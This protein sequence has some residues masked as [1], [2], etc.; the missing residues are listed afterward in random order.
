MQGLTQHGIAVFAKV[1]RL[2]QPAQIFDRH[3]PGQVG[4]IPVPVKQVKGGRRFAQ[5]V[6]ANRRA[7]D[8]VVRA[9]VAEG[10]GHEIGLQIALLARL[11]LD[12]V[13]EIVLQEHAGFALVREIGQCSEERRRFDRP[14]LALVQQCQRQAQRRAGD[15]VAYRVDRLDA[16]DLLDLG[17]GGQKAL[18]DIGIHAD[19]GILRPRIDPA[20][21]EQ[22]VALL[23]D[24]LYQTVLRLQIQNV[25]LVDPGRKD[26]QR[27]FVHLLG[28]G[29]VLNQLEHAV[30]EHHL[31]L[32]RADIAA[33]LERLA[34][35]QRDQ[36]LAFVALQ[37]GDQVF[38][39]LDQALALGLDR[40]HQRVR[41]GAQ[42]IRRRHHV[43][44]LLA[45]IFQ[46]GP[47][48]RVQRVQ[49]GDGFLDRLAGQQVL[50]LDVVEIGVRLPQRVGKPL[51]IGRVVLGRDQ[52]AR[53]QRLLGLDE[54][55]QRAAPVFYLTFEHGRGVLRQLRPIGRGRVQIKRRVR[56]LQF[57]A[58][59]LLPGEGLD[60]ALR[61]GLN[62]R[63]ICVHFVQIFRI[64]IFRSCHVHPLRLSSCAA[65]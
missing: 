63:E 57:A 42:K 46:P 55:L 54:M 7:I 12:S 36:Q 23:D 59:R 14:V 51:V 25:E 47:F 49:I 65:A 6:A 62:A 33:D 61:Q 28:L 41:V 17:D 16:A 8:Q 27:G 3:A 4:A 11:G 19:I 39:P 58:L 31:A 2:A 26:Q 9:K 22:R 32:G 18:L 56:R 10:L 15:A 24:P 38:Q 64:I 37:I 44:D 60:Q 53:A 52:L 29:L 20:D 5:H 45:E 30:A 40:L 48:A 35:R 43:D 13:N 21:H 34:I 1:V 50:L